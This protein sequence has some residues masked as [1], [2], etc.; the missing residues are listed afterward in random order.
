MFERARRPPGVRVII[1][2]EKENKI[3]L[4]RE[5]RREQGKYDYRLPG[6]KVI[7]TIA[8]M[9]AF[10]GDITREAT[11][12]AIQEAREEAGIVIR[13]PEL[14]HI[15]RCGANIEWD[16]YYF[17]AKEWSDTGEHERDDEGESD[18]TTAW[19]SYD[20]VREKILPNEMSEDRSVA[21]VLK[22][23]MR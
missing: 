20:E 2:D 10:D 7:D 18:L 3:L 22:W 17:V 1:V 9:R 23:M 6:G 8:E 19:Y 5:Y 4:S 16:L 15:S 13:H 12:A 14:I 21:V 11:D